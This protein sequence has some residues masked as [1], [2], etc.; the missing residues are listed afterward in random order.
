MLLA[1]I[2]GIDWEIYGLSNTLLQDL[3]IVELGVMLRR[4]NKENLRKNRKIFGIWRRK[5]LYLKINH[6]K[7]GKFLGKA[8]KISVFAVLIYPPG[9]M[10]GCHKDFKDT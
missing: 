10:D 8:G 6:P 5:N 3:K 7:N 4:P 1:Y 9:W 2:G